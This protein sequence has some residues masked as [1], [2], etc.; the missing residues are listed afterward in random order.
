ML[1][2]TTWFISCLRPIKYIF[3]KLALTKKLSHWQVILFEFEI[4]FIT[5]KV[6]KGPAI[7]NYLDE[8]PIENWDSME[9]F[10]SRRESTK[11][12]LS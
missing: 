3:E 10:F 5:S 11:H 2:Y 12:R 8:L 6:I 7:E 9:M 1:Y 4:V